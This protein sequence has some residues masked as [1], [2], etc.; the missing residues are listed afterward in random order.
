MT[1]SSARQNERKTMKKKLFEATLIGGLAFGLYWSALAAGEEVTVTGI[2]ACAKCIL[3][4]KDVKDHIK[5]ITVMKNGVKQIYYLVENDVAKK[6]G[7]Q[8]CKK[9]EKIT[10]TGS[11]QTVDGKLELTP[12]KI[13]LVEDKAAPEPPPQT[14]SK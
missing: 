4:E 1:H 3:R 6:F 14:A 2:G 9:P 11:L 7:N 13:A 5:S 10:A 8:L 12:T